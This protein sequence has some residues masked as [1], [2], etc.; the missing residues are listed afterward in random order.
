MRER[1]LGVMKADFLWGIKRNRREVFLK[2]I[3]VQRIV[4]LF[5]MHEV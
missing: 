2:L 3:S 4:I 5:N 1:A